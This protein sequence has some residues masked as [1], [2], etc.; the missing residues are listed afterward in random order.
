MKI[1]P[2]TLLLED[3]LEVM[4]LTSGLKVWDAE[5]FESNPPRYY[6]LK[7]I[8]ACMKAL[9]IQSQ[10]VNDFKYGGWCPSISID[11]IER[12]QNFLKGPF[13][14]DYESYI[15]EHS[16]F[17]QD[18]MFH[19]LLEI[20]E[21]M[22]KYK[23]LH[24]SVLAASGHFLTPVHILQSLQSKQESEEKAIDEVLYLLMNPSL[25]FYSREELIANFGFPDVDLDEI[26]LEWV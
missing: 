9:N 13:Q 10:S 12:I 11:A 21:I 18:Y 7:R 17:S 23:S 15:D 5:P 25:L 24:D 19:M 2:A 14:L 8:Q 22:S 1:N 4:S 26:D 16:H 3:Y 20:R 6:R